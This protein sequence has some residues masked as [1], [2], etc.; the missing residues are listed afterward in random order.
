MEMSLV[1]AT[2]LQQFQLR[3]APDQGPVEPE[4][5]VA[6]RPRE[7]LRVRVKARPQCP[8]PSEPRPSRIA[9]DGAP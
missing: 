8:E 3:L 7:G 4:V 1:M 9:T 2:V 6:I 5:P